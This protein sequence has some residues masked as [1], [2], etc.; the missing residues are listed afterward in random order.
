[1]CYESFF[2]I[3]IFEHNGWMN[4]QSKIC[5]LKCLK[6]CMEVDL[7]LYACVFSF[8]MYVFIMTDI[9]KPGWCSLS[10]NLATGQTTKEFWFNSQLVTDF[11]SLEHSGGLWSP[12]SCSVGANRC[13]FRSTVTGASTTHLH[14]LPILRMCGATPPLPCVPSWS[15]LPLNG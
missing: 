4:F 7:N 14:Q 2:C 10:S 5:Q 1:M 13:F 9:L 12:L 8:T 15:T 3:R 6:V 11:Y